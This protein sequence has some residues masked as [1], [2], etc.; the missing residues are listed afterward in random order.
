MYSIEELVHTIVSDS[1]IGYIASN[2]TGNICFVNKQIEEITGW[3][4]AELINQNVGKVCS[5]PGGIKKS[6]TSNDSQL[7]AAVVFRKDGS[8]ITLPAQIEEISKLLKKSQFSG[9]LIKLRPNNKTNK[10]IDKV[11][12]EFV[13]TVSHELR[14]PLTSIKG[15]S[16]TLLKTW[17]KLSTD[18]KRK[19]LT[20]IKE[21]SERLSR[22]VED[23]LA[24]SRLE[25]Q[26]YKPTIRSI[27]LR[28]IVL[29]VYETLES[30]SANHKI[31]VNIEDDIPLIKADPDR[32]EQILTNL[33][34]NAI[35][36]SPGGGTVTVCSTAITN[37]Y[38]IKDKVKIEVSDQGI[39][40]PE[41][42]LPKIFTK[43]GRLDNPLT[44]QAQGTG[45]GLF[46]T[47]SLVLSLKGEITVSSKPGETVFTVILPAEIPSDAIP[48]T[49]S[50]DINKE[51]E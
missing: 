31:V 12:M 29:K 24:V 14:T 9:Y 11:Q 39:G 34:D 47:K 6:L 18:V 45:L 10:N 33:I 30:K 50:E 36:Y 41:G 32:L 28:N 42:D 51:N 48:L 26:S 5:F 2:E 4:N 37:D 15:F 20:I 46:I 25:S 23:L 19:Y 27:N 35:K 1:S 44:R 40:I 7:L 38:K 21:Q 13:S 49:S 16:E 3:S 8:K 22:L 43:F 17:D